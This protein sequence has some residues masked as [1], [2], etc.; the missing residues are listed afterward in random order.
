MPLRN[1]PGPCPRPSGERF[2]RGGDWP[3]GQRCA[4]RTA[5]QAV[6]DL[7]YEMMREDILQK[8][9]RIGGRRIGRGAP[10][11]L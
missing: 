9:K 8:E 11:R 5:H 1:L 2:Q 7:L 6:D 3:M 10:H 4:L